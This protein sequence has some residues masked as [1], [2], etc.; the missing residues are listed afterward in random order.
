MSKRTDTKKRYSIQRGTGYEAEQADINNPEWL[1]Y[2]K[3]SHNERI[4]HACD[5]FNNNDPAVLTESLTY[6]GERRRLQEDTEDRRL[7]ITPDRYS[8][9]LF[10]GEI[11]ASNNSDLFY[12]QPKDGV[13]HRVEPCE[14]GAKED[15]ISFKEVRSIYMMHLY[16]NFLKSTKHNKNDDERDR[17]NFNC[18]TLH[19]LAS[20]TELEQ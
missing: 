5:I 13:V 7:F 8:C 1:K 16:T 12:G 9:D 6:F 17:R 3:F 10:E 14:G 19:L 18:L 15:S 2:E 4:Q 20:L 11:V